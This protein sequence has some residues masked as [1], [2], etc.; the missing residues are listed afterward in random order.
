MRPPSS[1]AAIS[2]LP[3]NYDGDKRVLVVSC[4]A[5]PDLGDFRTLIEI[6]ERTGA[7]TIRRTCRYPPTIHLKP[8]LRWIS[9]FL[10][11]VSIQPSA[12]NL[13]LFFDGGRTRARTLDPLIK[14]NRVIRGGID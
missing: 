9:L 1:T 14:R 13:L 7:E 8:V 4:S 10:F 2:Y 11:K 3:A 5:P 12:L 6:V